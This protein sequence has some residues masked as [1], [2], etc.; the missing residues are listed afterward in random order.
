MTRRAASA[1]GA[2][3]AQ[4]VAHVADRTG[5]ATQR[6]RDLR[7]TGP[8]PV[9]DVDL[10][11]TPTTARRGEDDHLEGPAEATVD[12]AQRQQVSARRAT[13]MGPRGTGG[14]TSSERPSRHR[15]VA[16]GDSGWR[17]HAPRSAMRAPSTR[18]TSP[19]ITGPATRTRSAGSSEPSA[20]MKQTMSAEAAWSPAQ[21]AAPKPRRASSTT[22]PRP[23]PGRC[24]RSRRSCRCR[25]PRS[26]GSRQGIAA[27]RPGS[28]VASSSTGSTTSGTRAQGTTTADD[29]PLP[30]DHRRR[31]RALGVAVLVVAAASDSPP[32]SVRT[33]TS[34]APTS[35]PHRS[36]G[37]GAFYRLVHAHAGRRGAGG[38]LGRP[39]P[40]RRGVAV[41]AAGRGGRHGRAGRPR[42]ASPT[43][44]PGS[45]TRS[46]APPTTPVASARSAATRATTWPPST[47]QARGPGG[48]VI[49]RRLPRPRP[50]P[51]ARRG[52]HPV[53]ADPTWVRARS[54][55]AILMVW[56]GIA[57]TVVAVCL[58]TSC[59][60]S[61]ATPPARV[62]VPFV[63]LV[64]A[65]VWSHTFDSF[66]AGVGA[67][68]AWA[69]VAPLRGIVFSPSGICLSMVGRGHPDVRFARPAAFRRRALRLSGTPVLRTFGARD[70]CRWPS[71]GTPERAP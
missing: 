5:G 66:F 52:A 43:T 2:G 45:P 53:G 69:V 57:L 59:D 16:V 12:D 7:A 6:A 30:A 13:R 55:G 14:A 70:W 51:P 26:G 46:T 4:H 20:S 42:S 39:P 15:E 19:A 61:P 54:T 41:G 60:G 34:R 27:S 1:S 44:P 36:T 58:G 62:A 22:G 47:T 3:P 23:A 38:A 56:S 8:G 32:S 67:C 21:Q 65:A 25:G 71:P 10:A 49:A 24:G 18:S 17:G 29:P 31:W 11:D 37:S 63:V 35:T 33:S 28:A 68:A 9:G 48:E 64:P 40:L 50:G